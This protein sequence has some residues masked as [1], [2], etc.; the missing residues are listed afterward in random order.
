MREWC[1]EIV[2]PALVLCEMCVARIELGHDEILKRYREVPS[3][4]KETKY[5]A[6]I[7]S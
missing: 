2:E 6:A 1:N 4:S 7:E 5:T 3:A